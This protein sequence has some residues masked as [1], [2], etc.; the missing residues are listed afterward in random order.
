[1]EK[2]VT[3]ALV[4]HCIDFRFQEYLDAWLQEHLGYGSYDRVSLAG[5]VFDFKAVLEQI[6]I[7]VRL[8]EIGKVVL[9]NHEN[10]GAYGAEGDFE[11]HQKDLRVAKKAIQT[12]FPDLKVELYFLRLD[13]MFKPIES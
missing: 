2:H 8:H 5:G 1:M 13:G 12:D 4:V 11:R 7:S 6:E 9:I 3:D 10:C